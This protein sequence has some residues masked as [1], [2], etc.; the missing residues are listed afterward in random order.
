[1]KKMWVILGTG[2]FAF[3]LYNLIF[4]RNIYTSR[5]FVIPILKM[6]YSQLTTPTGCG[7]MIG[8]GFVL[9][10][11]GIIRMRKNNY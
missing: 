4:E 8:V 7:I 2:L 9:I 6:R 10:V 1:M 3:G 5:D 11:I